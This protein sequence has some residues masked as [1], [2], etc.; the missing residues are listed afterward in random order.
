M[1][2]TVGEVYRVAGQPRG[3]AFR[4]LSVDGG[5]VE[6]WG[7]RGAYMAFRSF[8]VSKVQPAPL[9]RSSWPTL[10]LP[11]EERPIVE[12]ARSER[13]TQRKLASR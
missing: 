5:T 3:S 6:C 1:T 7:G 9:R 13:R 12:R 8:P 4:V 11:V 2:P 10:L